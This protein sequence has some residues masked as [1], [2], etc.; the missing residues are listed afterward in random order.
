MPVLETDHTL[1]VRF[2]TID[3]HL[4]GNQGTG[5]VTNDMH[6]VDLQEISQAR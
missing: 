1:Q 5:R 6:R 3:R 2:G 4:E